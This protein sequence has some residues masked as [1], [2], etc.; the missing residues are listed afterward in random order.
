MHQYDPPFKSQAYPTFIPLTQMPCPDFSQEKQAEMDHLFTEIEDIKKAEAEMRDYVNKM[1]QQ[2]E[3]EVPYDATLAE[4]C[5]EEYY[6]Q[7][8]DNEA[9]SY[10]T[11]SSAGAH[12][13]QSFDTAPMNGGVERG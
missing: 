3:E 12:A 6:E 11:H 4:F 8:Y 2:Q 7:Y 9:E 1:R 5:V 13:G 10:N